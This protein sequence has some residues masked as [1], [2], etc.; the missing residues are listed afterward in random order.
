M[1]HDMKEIDEG[2]SIPESIDTDTE[3]E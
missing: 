3:Q 2:E 1:C